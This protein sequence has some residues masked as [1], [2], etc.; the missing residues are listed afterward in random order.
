MLNKGNGKGLSRSHTTQRDQAPHKNSF[1]TVLKVIPVDDWHRTWETDRTIMLR[2]TS[3]R[4][5]EQVDKMLMSAVV[6]LRTTFW[7]CQRNITND[8]IMNEITVMVS[9][10]RL[11]TL[12]LDFTMWGKGKL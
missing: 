12:V 4:V 3:K 11:T 5:T 9:T 2:R 8:H 10:C 1:D 7:D 6:R